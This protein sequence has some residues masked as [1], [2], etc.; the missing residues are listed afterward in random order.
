MVTICNYQVTEK[1]YE[2][3]NSI[4]YR[5]YR[6]NESQ[7]VIL[8]ML[9]DVY[10][11]PERIAR[12]KREF[13][14][15]KSLDIEGVADVY[16]LESD[17]NRWVMTVEDFGGE[18]LI[19]L[20][21]NIK[22]SIGDFLGIAIE[23]TEIIGQV[24]QRYITHKDINPANII[25]NPTTHQIKLIDFG[26][27]AA[28]SR[29]NIPLG[30]PDKLEG[31]LP[32]LSPEQTGRMNR[33]VDYRTDFYSLGVT[34][35]QLL[36]GQLPFIS[37]NAIEWVH[38][39]IAKQPIPPHQLNP[40]IPQPVSEIILKL[41]AKNAED[42]YQSAYGLKAD[43]EEC[44]NQWC[45]NKRIN[46]FNL[47]RQDVCDRFQIAQ[48]LYG[49]ETEINTLLAGFARVC[50]GS[51]ELMLVCGYSGIGKSALVRE[52]YKPITQQ[53]GYFIVGKF[54]QFQRDIPYDALVQALR[55]LV[56]QLLTESEAQIA[57][58]RNKLLAAL[59]ENG[60]LI[61]DVIPELELI[62]GAQPTVPEVSPTEAQN[63]FNLVFQNFIRVFTQPEHPLVIFLDDLQWAD[64]ASLQLIK[65]LMTAPDNHYLFVIGAY[66]DNEVSEAH[67]LMLTIDEIQK[68]KEIVNFIQLSALDLPNI[69]QLIA[70]ATK[71]LPQQS[72]PLAE[73]I[74]AKTNGN[75]FFINEFLEA[76]Y[77]EQLLKFD[78]D[79][80]SWQWN[81]EQI[82]A[83][84]ITDNVVELMTDRAKKIA[85]ETKQV[86]KLAACIGNQYD[87]QTLAIVSQKSAQETAKNLWPAIVEGLILP[88]SDAYKPIE[89][90]V[91]GWEEKV[92]VKYKFAHDRIQQAVYSLIPP[93]EKQAVHWQVG[94]LLLQNTPLD[95]QEQKI[96]DLVNQLN[97]GLDLIEAQKERSEL[98]RLNLIAGKRA[99]ASSA[100]KSASHYLQIGLKL[101]DK[102]S[103][104]EQYD[105]GLDLYVEAAE[106][107]YLNDEFEQTEALA[108]V[109]Q[110][111]AKT[112]S[113][114]LKVYQVRIRAYC[115]NNHQLL[116]AVN[117]GREILDL[118]GVHLPKKPSKAD[119]SLALEKAKSAWSGKK[120]SELINLPAMSDPEKLAAI[121]ILS[122]LIHP[123]Y[124][125]FPQLLPFIASNMVGLS[126]EYGNTALS[127]QGYA[128][129]GM[130]L[131]GMMLDLDAGYEFGQLALN[132]V[133]RFNAKELKCW[134]TFQVNAFTIPWK[135]HFIE[136]FQPS[137]ESYQ[138][139]LE[140]GDLQ[141]AVFGAYT[142]CYHAYW[143]GK[144]LGW[145]EREIAKYSQGMAQINQKHVQSYQDRYWQVVL[146]LMGES[147]NSWHL[148]G[149]KYD[150]EKMLQ[151]IT[152]SNDI[153]SIFEIYLQRLTLCYLFKNLDI[154]IETAPIAE[155]YVGGALS[156][157][158]VVCFYFYDSLVRLAVCE[159][160]Q[161]IKQK[162]HLKKVNANQKKMEVWAHHAPMNFLHKFY[163]VEAERARVLEK[164]TEAR[165][166]YDRAISLAQENQYLNEEALANELAGKFYLA[167]GQNHV[168]RHYLQDAHYAYQR[169][170]AQAK[171][172]DLEE[173]YPQFLA[174]TI[175]GFPHTTLT[176][177]TTT[178]G[179]SLQ[180]NL[181]FSS[182]LKASQMV[183]SEIVLEKLLAK[184]M[185]IAIENAG[186]QRSFLILP[187]PTKPENEEINWAIEAEA[188]VEGDR[189]TIL[190]SIPIDS[191]D[192]ATGV[193]LLSTAI[194][195]YVARS[196]ENVVLNNATEEGQFTGDAYILAT[197]P[198]SILC[199]PLLDR[200]KLAGIIYLENNLAIGA[201]TPER[202]ETLTIIAAQAAISIENAT[203]YEQLEDYNRTL[204]QKVEERTNELSHTLDILKATQAELVIENALL[205]SAE[206]PQSYNYQV[207]GSLPIDAPTYVV[208]SADRYLY[209][210]LRLGQLC[211]I[212]NTRQMGKSSLR[213]QIMKRLQSEGFVCTAIDVSTISNSQTTLE[214]WYAGLAYL[215]ASG[216]NLLDKVNIRTWW[217]ERDFLS[218]VQRLSEFINEV[219]LT[220]ISEKII[221]FI[222]EIDSVLDLQ[223]DSSALFG[224]IRTCYNKRADSSDYQRL[225]FVLLGV[226]TPSQ[227]IQDRNR[228]P[229]NVGQ[230]VQ[231]NGFQAHE[232]QPLLQGL[233]QRVS[234]PQTLLNEVIAW[235]GGQPFL[236]QKVCQLICSS[237]ASI[238]TNDE[239]AYVE[240]LVRSHI[241]EDW[242]SQDQP[243]HLR[244]IRDRILS[245]KQRA[246]ELLQLY[247]EILDRGQVLAVDSLAETDLIMSGLVVKKGDYLQV[248]NRIYELIFDARWV[249]KYI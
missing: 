153:Y 220:V 151:I 41:M 243:E 23:I 115:N 174:Q 152:E 128:A 101:L 78:F 51:S 147:N 44:Y 105:L 245:D 186:A 146:N 136:V 127:A 14:T 31:T 28:I 22:L 38:S 110:K 130:I 192:A 62:I 225:N 61:V 240:G 183:S 145:L 102:N 53:Q 37:N 17:Q 3:Q 97:W 60:Q 221:I 36:T 206:E 18:S 246:I 33:S 87:L 162:Q 77:K 57:E 48:K 25:F 116:Q 233:T 106:A 198:K 242:E 121:A 96:F 135:K 226:A 178:S 112:V 179:E 4:V 94:K 232:A 214:Q 143:M 46:E 194:V 9:K 83:R 138:I 129:Y 141:Y 228:T 13:E 59:R 172:K 227:L 21:K 224:I 134:V 185:K 132:L 191:V 52:V 39:H 218:S 148:V 29:E 223:F 168:A 209:K 211:Y 95:K 154:A 67:P 70:D 64:R 108:K 180:R 249:Q 43:L 169:W 65:L 86:L 159:E 210:A 111:Y 91:D 202:V 73:L 216:F 176:I 40:E 27:S 139:G 93:T 137:L 164:N 155:K 175:S 204:E 142:Y 68:A 196:Q 90:D 92:N 58:W 88:L 160:S 85:E 234:N 113:D 213:V 5:G 50:E 66:R 124:E 2:S 125:A 215:L 49:R 222:D 247:R 79:R 181:D 188:A 184:L 107:A 248:N 244:T 144:E 16:S 34:F 122:E 163:L 140:T 235:T 189:M 26:I 103:W 156:T 190:Q 82:Q 35:Y 123:T 212:L 119:T 72:L 187:S 133:E 117:I 76:L 30:N 182:V 230:A 131:C 166:Y 208:R 75:P 56:Q 171:V 71:C 158:L 63:R 15:T 84:N 126:I 229:F 99:K 45:S 109:V 173:R 7:S 170:G 100:Y 193:S 19:G 12:F 177:S 1:L 236:T 81:L 32:Y 207:G 157:I 200:G 150:E 74:L 89:L 149:T 239:A 47:G 231:L 11:S 195:H 42:R 20:T 8:K 6:E 161:K 104:Q 10:P 201:F 24:H 80:G 165:E 199:T 55:S 203:L 241:I 217:R 237:E 205:R 114:K 98:A 118:L 54:D 219:L 69:N 120:P 167:K 197:Q 238:P